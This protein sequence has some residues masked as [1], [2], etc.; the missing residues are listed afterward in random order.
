MKMKTAW[1]A[2]PDDKYIQIW[3]QIRQAIHA[4]TDRNGA[5]P[6]V[7]DILNKLSRDEQAALFNRLCCDYGKCVM[8]SSG[9]N[10]KQKLLLEFERTL[11]LLHRMAKDECNL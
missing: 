3:L 4:P 6:A 10:R 2:I 8:F 5:T 1:N 11:D 7:L 9:S